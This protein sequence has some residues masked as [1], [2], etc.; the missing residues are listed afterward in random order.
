M[1]KYQLKTPVVLI[2]FK[3]P[4]TT[5]KVFEAI[6]QAKP[7]KLLVIADGPRV[8]VPGEAE[9]CAAARAIIDRVDWDCEVLTN[10]SDTNLGLRNRV[11]SG[12]NWVFKLVEEAIILEDDC[13][14]HLTFF[15]FC[16]ELLEKYK[17][18]HRIAHI[19]G[20]NFQ[21]G[22]QWT[23]YS[24]YF[25]RYT[26]CWGWATW[27]RAWNYY[28]NDMKLWSS[29]RETNW[30]DNFLQNSIASQYWSNNFQKTY[31]GFNSW[32]YAWFFSCWSNDLLT[33][34]P[35]VNLVSN[36]GFDLEATHTKNQGNLTNLPTKNIDFP[37]LHPPQV[38]QNLE[39]DSLTEKNVISGAFQSKFIDK[40]KLD[41]TIENNQ[42]TSKGV[43][44]M[45]KVDLGCGTKKPSGYI[46]VDQFPAD[47]VDIV[48]DLARKFPFPDNSIDEIRAYDF[49]EHL[50]NAL[51][52]M[53]EIWRIGKHDAKVDIFVPSTDGRGAFR[54]SH[55]RQLLEYPFF[56]LLLY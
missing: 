33:I 31:Q 30:L 32:N 14:P 12:L 6:R 48:A 3:R 17:H 45:L 26:H 21:F 36:I 41:S 16:E 43:N 39:A 37:L 4:D 18:N 20:N 10:Y 47:D 46:G 22:K 1:K 51:H 13:I 55:S 19:T 7:P 49:I 2:I 35:N 50:P 40:N 38:F 5:E 8:D 24:Y 27:K 44:D 11:S 54:E 9:K 25:S 23:Q 34:I 56:F 28:D 42:N 53:N 29:V 52:T 15:R